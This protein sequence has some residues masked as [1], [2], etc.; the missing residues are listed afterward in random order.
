SH[1]S[2][3]GRTS[4][5]GREGGKEGLVSWSIREAIPSRQGK[6]ISFF[7]APKKGGIFFPKFESEGKKTLSVFFSPSEKT[8]HVFLPGP[9]KRGLVFPNGKEPPPS[10]VVFF[11][12]RKQP[13]CP[14]GIFSSAARLASPPER[15]F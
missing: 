8:L 9:L 11:S 5:A 1:R 15:L 6:G 7:L 13:A 4:F 10:G 12:P 2:R 3:W 14:E